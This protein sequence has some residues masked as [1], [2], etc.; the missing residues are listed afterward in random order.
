M[1]SSI[2]YQTPE[3]INANPYIVC[4]AR[5]GQ[6]QI[7]RTQVWAGNKYEANWT[8]Q[9]KLYRNNEENLEIRI[10]A[11]ESPQS[12]QAQLLGVAVIPITQALQM[13][14][15]E[16]CYTLNIKEKEAGQDINLIQ[17]QQSC[18]LQQIQN[19]QQKLTYPNNTNQLYYDSA[20]P[21]T[22]CLTNSQIKLVS[23]P[24]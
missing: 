6:N 1:I 23:L 15:Q 19:Q 9:L 20:Q 13:Q 5:L 11:M 7:K 22:Q 14:N 21:Q 2:L 12:S 3:N 18:Q 24:Q 8:D 4:V 17:Q 16:L 10:S